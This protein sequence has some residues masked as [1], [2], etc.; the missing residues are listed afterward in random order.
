[1]RS[2]GRAAEFD[3][4]GQPLRLSGT[5]RDITSR[6]RAELALQEN[7]RRLRLVTDAVPAMIAYVDAEL[8]YRFC[9]RR[10]SQIMGRSEAE[11][12][13]RTVRDVVGEE[14]Y[15]VSRP[16]LERALAGE[17]CEH[18]RRH[19]WP[20]GTMAD[21]SVTYVPHVA[22]DR[23]QIVQQDRQRFGRAVQVPIEVRV[24]HDL[25]Q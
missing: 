12:L 25:S 9:N 22:D 1:M 18:E 21:L 19:R 2:T 23:L 7:E 4:A 24:A 14:Q 5:N 11:I 3:S 10:Y 17:Q 8:R 6:K 16:W 15:A 13:G 20:N